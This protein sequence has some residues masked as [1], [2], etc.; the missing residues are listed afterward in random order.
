MIKPFKFFQGRPSR[1]YQYSDR[2]INNSLY[3]GFRLAEL[4]D[5]VQQIVSDPNYD[6]ANYIPY[7]PNNAQHHGFYVGVPNTQLELIYDGDMDKLSIR[8]M[9]DEL[10]YRYRTCIYFTNLTLNNMEDFLNEHLSGTSTI[11]YI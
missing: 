2:I 4:S 8:S 3:G 11:R 6:P 5:R 1:L 9:L 10:I 7:V